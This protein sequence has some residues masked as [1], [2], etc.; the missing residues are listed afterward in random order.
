MSH[1]QAGDFIVCN[2]EAE[3]IEK[4]DLSGLSKDHAYSVLG[5]IQLENG[6]R[7]V[8]VRNPWSNA[9]ANAAFSNSDTLN[10]GR[11]RKESGHKDSDYGIFF[12]DIETYVIQFT[13][14]YVTFDVSNWSSAKFLKLSDK[15]DAANPGVQTETCGPAC[16][17]HT[18]TLRSDID[19]TVYLQA[20]T[21]NERG[22]PDKCQLEDNQ[23]RHSMIVEGR[24]GPFVWNYGDY[25]LEPFHL[26][27]NVP[28]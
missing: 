20:F 14:T 11:G 1:D 23:L 7:L 28:I 18:M 9:L 13:E 21:W 22:I 26:A 8:K 19:Q 2:S 4:E 10:E 15:Y 25:M 24:P 16:N 5:T 6:K 12:I 17:R 3:K 27:A